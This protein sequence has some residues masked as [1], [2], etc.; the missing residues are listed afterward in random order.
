M[1][2]P[3]CISAASEN[4]I[5]LIEDCGNQL[6]RENFEESEGR[7]DFSLSVYDGSETL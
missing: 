1:Q 4:E 7:S 2:S 6:K 3:W 5:M